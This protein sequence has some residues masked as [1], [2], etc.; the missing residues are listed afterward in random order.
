MN[1][2]NLQEYYGRFTDDDGSKAYFVLM[3]S[4]E[5][6]TETIRLHFNLKEP[7]QEQ[8]SDYDDEDDQEPL[9]ET[10]VQWNVSLDLT[11]TQDKLMVSKTKE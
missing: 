5:Y 3:M 10:D 4:Y 7:G 9:S 6:A 2:V 1:Y 11:K 8:E